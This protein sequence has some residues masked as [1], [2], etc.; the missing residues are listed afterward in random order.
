MSVRA[1]VCVHEYLLLSLRF[2]RAYGQGHSKTL[3]VSETSHSKSKDSCVFPICHS[4]GYVTAFKSFSP[5]FI[6]QVCE[7]FF[8]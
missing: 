6:F 7:I 1:H 2:S 8:V 4:L 3:Q 5:G